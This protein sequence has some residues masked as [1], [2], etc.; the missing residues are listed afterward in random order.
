MILGSSPP[1]ETLKEPAWIELVLMENACNEACPMCPVSADHPQMTEMPPELIDRIL[2]DVRDRD[3]LIALTAN[4]EPLL[5]RAFEHALSRCAELGLTPF[6]FTNG[7]LL[8]RSAAL[9]KMIAAGTV[10]LR[11]SLD[12]ARP[13]TYAK[14]R[15]SRAR[16]S[17][18][19]FEKVLN[20]IRGLVSKRNRLDAEGRPYLHAG[21]VL[22]KSNIAEFPDFA[23]LCAELGFDSISPTHLY[24]HPPADPNESLFFAQELSDENCR[25][26]LERAFA[27]KLRISRA[28]IRQMF[29]SPALRERML[30]AGLRRGL[31]LEEAP[32][33]EKSPCPKPWRN[34]LIRADGTAYPCCHSI[35]PDL[36]FANLK[37]VSLGKAWS[38]AEMRAFR[39]SLMSANIPKICR[40]CR[41]DQN[42]APGLR[43]SHLPR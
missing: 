38:S 21:F 23:E 22:M 7:L 33:P 15:P 41:V 5:S 13:E 2:E 27:R 14:L 11:I 26:A 1:A 43:A 20:N 32:A 6:I 9:K 8:D 36:S 4:G 18:D 29:F 39:D 35:R 17:E 16:S 10:H 28:G 31:I 37:T 12:A 25:E 3:A 30:A 19:R 34:L 40:A 24:A 42:G